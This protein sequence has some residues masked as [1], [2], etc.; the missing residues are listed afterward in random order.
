MPGDLQ[1][2]RALLSKGDETGSEPATLCSQLL[3]VGGGAAQDSTGCRSGAKKI[4]NAA[5]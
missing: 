4:G 3:R 1:N 2:S 5:V